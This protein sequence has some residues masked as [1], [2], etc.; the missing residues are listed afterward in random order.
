VRDRY[1]R[2][3]KKVAESS[4]KRQYKGDA[5]ASLSMRMLSSLFNFAESNYEDADGRA[6]VSTNP[7][8]CLSAVRKGWRT[9]PRRQTLILP[10]ELRNFYLG[11]QALR[12][13]TARDYLLFLVLT[14]LRRN[15]AAQL[16]WDEVDLT[17]GFL[18]IPSERTKNHRAHGL[19]LSDYLLSMLKRRQQ[20]STSKF[21]FPGRED[22]KGGYY[23]DPSHA[24]DVVAKHV[25][26]NFSCHDCRR[27]LITIAEMLEVPPYSLKS[28]VNHSTGD[29]TAGYIISNIERLREPMQRITSYMLQLMGAPCPESG[30]N[31]RSIHSGRRASVVPS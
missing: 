6:V 17:S 24:I 9:V 21:V 12:N 4:G 13:D 22:G 8:K 10:G 7:V 5:L 3:I 27:T 28:L 26:K 1:G 29:V 11:V 15:E 20:T 16:V 30:S 18:I 14:G 23:S 25:G 19:P 31:I 2:T